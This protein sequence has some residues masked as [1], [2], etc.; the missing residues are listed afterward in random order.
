MKALTM[1]EAQ[2][3]PD[4]EFLM[5][6]DDRLGTAEWLSLNGLREL[7]KLFIDHGHIPRPDTVSL[8][9]IDAIIMEFDIRSSDEGA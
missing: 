6:Y 2:A 9:E 1:R 5:N 3:H 7:I 8:E 4:S